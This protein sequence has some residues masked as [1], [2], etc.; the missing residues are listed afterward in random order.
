MGR[1]AALMFVLAA[2]AS[3]VLAQPVRTA[4]VEAQLHSARTAVAP[5][6]RFTIVLRQTIREGW[7]TYWRN[8]GAAGEATEIAWRLPPGWIADEI[9]WPAP[10][11]IPFETLIN[12]GYS[13]EVLLPVDLS[14]PAN[15]RPG[16]N[17]TLSAHATWVVCSNICV[18]EEGDLSLALRVEAQGRDD[19]I[20]GPRVAAAVA[21]LPAPFDPNGPLRARVT[22]GQPP[23]LSI[24]FPGE[25]LGDP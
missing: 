3:P 19:P 13:D 6:E 9:R 12:Y 23:R 20:W 16:Q 17:L 7:H 1:F 2:L 21:A 22:H 25:T 15:A 14:A 5:G 10:H 18:F 8:P 4:N 11:A 24:A